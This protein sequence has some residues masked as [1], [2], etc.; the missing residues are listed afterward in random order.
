MSKENPSRGRSSD[1]ISD[2]QNKILVQYKENEDIDDELKVINKIYDRFYVSQKPPNKSTNNEFKTKFYKYIP[3]DP[4]FKDPKVYLNKQSLV[5]KKKLTNHQYKMRH[6]VRKQQ[7][8]SLLNEKVCGKPKKPGYDENDSRYTNPI[9]GY[10][11]NEDNIN[12]AEIKTKIPFLS[13]GLG[14]KKERD[15]SVPQNNDYDA[16][17]KSESLIYSHNANDQNKNQNF[18]QNS[19]PP[20]NP[21][22]KKSRRIGSLNYNRFNYL[23]KFDTKT[24]QNGIY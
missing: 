11:E 2:Y 23:Y 21:E 9:F 20:A 16:L 19:K 4:L 8:F 24:P 17:N 6:E 14:H 13:L 10:L 5:E 1:D 15:H 7:Y 18:E 12:Q 3:Q 22:S